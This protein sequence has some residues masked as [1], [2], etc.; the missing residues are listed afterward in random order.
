MLAEWVIAAKR[1]PMR[2]FLA[3]LLVPALAGVL[4]GCPRPPGGTAKV[5]VIGSEPKIRDPALGALPTP[6]AVLL[7]TVAQGLVRFDATGNIV[8]GLAER[9]NVSDDGLSYIF[10]IAAAEWPDGRKITAQQV[11]RILKRQLTARS[12]NPL[13]DALGAV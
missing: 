12:K 7:Q 13:K 3:M 6:D 9:W 4:W 8:R 1:A 11:A 2:R 10:R 5:V